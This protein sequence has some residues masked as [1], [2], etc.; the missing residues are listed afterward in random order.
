MSKVVQWYMHP[1]S[2]DV[3]LR[4]TTIGSFTAYE[5]WNLGYTGKPWLLCDAPKPPNLV[6]FVNISA[7]YDIKREEPGLPPKQSATNEDNL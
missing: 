1:K 6:E 2:M 5:W 7:F 3:A 4:E